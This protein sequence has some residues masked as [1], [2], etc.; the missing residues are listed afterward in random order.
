MPTIARLADVREADVSVPDPKPFVS[1]YR[2]LEREFPEADSP[3]NGTGDVPPTKAAVKL[4]VEAARKARSRTVNA[5]RVAR[6]VSLEVSALDE[7]RALVKQGERDKAVAFGHALHE[8]AATRGLGCAV[9]GVALLNSSG[10]VKAWSVMSEIAGTPAS[11]SVANELYAAAFG[12]LG[13]DAAPILDAD[14]ESGRYRSWSGLALLRVAQ[15]ALVRGLHDQS[16][17]LITTA[18]ELP[19]AATSTSVRKELARLATWLPEGSK[20][21]EIPQVPGAINYGVIGY[22]QPDV[23][24]RNIGDYIQT[25]ASMG[26]I[27]RQQNFRFVGNEDIVEF[28]GELRST[29]KTERLVDGPSATLNLFELNRDGNPF[30]AI[31]EQTYAVTFGWFMHHMFGQGFAIPFH[32]NVRPIILSVYVRFPEMLTPEVVDY[33]RKYAPIGC[34]DWQSVALLR[35]VGVPAFFSGCMT[36]TVDTVFRRDGED[37]RDATIYVDSPQTGPGVSRTQ[38]QT[39]IRDLS[40]VENLRLARDWVSHYHLEYDKV[41]TSRLHCNLPSRSVGSKVTFLPKNRSDTRFGGLIDTTD[42]DFE[43]IRQGILDKVAVVLQTIASGASEDEVYATWREVTAPAM[44]EA[45]EFLGSKHLR[46]LETAEVDSLVAASGLGAAATDGDAIDVVVDVRRGELKHLPR[47][48]RSIDAHTSAPVRV[49][50]VDAHSSSAEQE[51]L[52]AEDLP[53]TVR[54]LRPDEATLRELGGATPA[55]RHELTLALAS[56]ALPQAQRVVFL[57]AAAL[58]RQDLAT[59]ADVTPA[60]GTFVAAAAERHRGRQNG[61]ELIHRVSSRQGDDNHKALDFLIAAHREHSGQWETFDTNVMVVDLEAAR[62]DNLTGHILP[63][64]TDYGMTFR[65]A[66]NLHV[67]Q[68]HTVL[69]AEWNH[70][71]GYEVQE[72]PALVSWRDTTKPWS[73]SVTPFAGEWQAS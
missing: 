19:D 6:G 5:D 14:I 21:A 44:A 53:L 54:W 26:H 63:L 73:G 69:D 3:G 68:H 57:P 22:D 38:V 18:Q 34:R 24:S 72:D 49:W 15:K 40:F 30:Q 8:Q 61:L 2:A 46:V 39:G 45:D 59:L 13:D 62:R 36:T 48:L 60:D 27:V 33:L 17:L 66:V 12:A 29:T 7:V 67:G 4:K 28:A 71:P 41:I 70:A 47:L 52:L 64:V 56:A 43:R 51:K 58:V 11:Q 16:R 25:V 42:E 20:R 35:A 50:A 65:E 32:D 1:G 9:L 37:T 55:T 23:V 10:P 31:P